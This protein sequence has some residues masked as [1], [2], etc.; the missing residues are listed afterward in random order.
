RQVHV[1]PQ[2]RGR[3]VRFG[4]KLGRALGELVTI[5]HPDTLRRWIRED[6]K[7]RSKSPAKGRRRTAEDIR[8]LILKL[9][10]ENG[11]GYTRILGELKKLGIKAVSRNT[12]KNILKAQ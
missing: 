6:R 3:L 9:A 2:E 8:R 7:G 12:V 5:V 11:W 1:T 4:A 10:K